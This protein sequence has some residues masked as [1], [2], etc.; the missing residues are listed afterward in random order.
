MKLAFL[1]DSL[2]YG[3][4]TEGSEAWN[5]QFGPLGAENLGVPGD[6]TDDV[7]ERIEA[8]ELD[9]ARPDT[10]VLCVGTND[11]GSGRS[12]ERAARGVEACV[13]ALLARYAGARVVVLALLPRGDGGARGYGQLADVNAR[14]ER[15]AGLARVR[16]FDCGSA[17]VDAAGRVRPELYDMDLLHLAPAGY[18]AWA[19]SLAQAPFAQ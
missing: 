11:L 1:G 17:F 14:L 13:R 12:P 3:W 7:L 16:F 15:L 6:L 4:S 10:I 8:G 2:T 9:A 18:A 19:R 5:E